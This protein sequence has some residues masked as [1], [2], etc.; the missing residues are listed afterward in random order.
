MVMLCITYAQQIKHEFTFGGG[1]PSLAPCPIQRLM[2]GMWFLA[3]Q[4]P[5]QS[6]ELSAAGMCVRGH[7]YNVC[8]CIPKYK[9]AA[10]EA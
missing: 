4:L 6:V 8:M 2:S 3:G 5:G 9:H 1:S 7:C 10:L